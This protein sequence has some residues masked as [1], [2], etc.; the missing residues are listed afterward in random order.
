MENVNNEGEFMMSNSYT[1]KAIDFQRDCVMYS[2]Y[3]IIVYK[4]HNDL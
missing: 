1:A 2:V 3:I 4:M